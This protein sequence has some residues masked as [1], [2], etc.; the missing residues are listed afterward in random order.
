MR[1]LVLAGLALTMSC[2]RSAPS[3]ISEA[4]RP[5]AKRAAPTPEPP[6][7]LVVLPHP[8]NEEGDTLMAASEDELVVAKLERAALH[9]LVWPGEGVSWKKTDLAAREGLAL[10]AL[11]PGPT[12]IG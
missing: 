9:T 2:R 1:R 8:P 12:H 4:G 10:E 5:P 7:R 11:E 3:A 6:P